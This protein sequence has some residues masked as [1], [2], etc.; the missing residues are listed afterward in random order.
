MGSI[1][2]LP[3]VSDQSSDQ[4]G[5]VK[6][7]ERL[8]PQ[9]IEQFAI[10]DPDFVIGMN[11]RIPEDQTN[12]MEYDK[13]SISQLDN[14]IN[15]M[16]YWMESKIKPLDLPTNEA[17]AYFGLQEFRYV[18]MEIA[19]MKI[20]RPILLPSPRN[21]VQNTAALLEQTE[22]KTIFYSGDLSTQEPELQKLIPGLKMI[23]V[24]SL[25]EMTTAKT[26]HYPYTKTWDEARKDVVLIVH[27]SGSTGVPKRI[28]YNQTVLG[29]IDMEFA[30]PPVEG[31]TLS[32]TGLCKPGKPVLC[33]T[34]F[35]HL[36]GI[37]FVLG[38][39][40]NRYT[41]VFGLKDA[42]PTGETMYRMIKSMKFAGMLM[43]P[44]LLDQLF[45]SYGNEIKGSLNELEHA[46]WLGGRYTS[47]TKN[48]DLN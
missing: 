15:F 39:I 27:T 9:L 2:D 26:E 42:L 34:N 22:C 7:G 25:T 6:R 20:G 35:Y 16:A 13:L 11:A 47:H 10:E 14:A 31:R 17:I 41:A 8:L 33:G 40:F 30:L 38:A 4:H 18:V 28:A 45:S 48:K 24:P 21:A 44:S 46:N 32:S 23:S 29:R 1:T 12:P 43:V 5:T 3:S 36:S 19:A 37:L